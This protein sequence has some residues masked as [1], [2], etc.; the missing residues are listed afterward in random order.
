MTT[1]PDRDALASRLD[2]ALHA[3]ESW[4]VRKQRTNGSFR[5]DGAANS[6]STGLAAAALADL[7]HVHRA[8][9]AAKWLRRL[10]VTTALAKDG[11]LGGERGAVA[12]DRAAF[13]AGVDNGITRDVRYQWRRATAQAA[14]GLD[15]LR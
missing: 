13:K 15:A 12:F 8:D 11:A 9:L 7:G 1:D 3:A 14:V 10:Q 4:L 2:H 6:N 5:E